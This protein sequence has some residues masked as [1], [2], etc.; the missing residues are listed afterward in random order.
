MI[1]IPHDIFTE[2]SDVDPNTLANL[3]PLRALAGSWRATKGSDVAP[4]P[5]GPER[6]EF[7]E[8]ITFEPIDPQA[9]GP[10]LFYG[11]RYHIHIT[12]VEEDI[13]FHEQVGYW[14]WEPATGLMLQTLAIPRGQTAMASGQGKPGDESITLTAKRGQTNYGI[15]STDFLEEA[16]R[17]DEYRIQITFNPDGSWSYDIQTTLSVHGQDTPFIH[18][19]RNTLQRVGDAVPNPWA[20]I[21]AAKTEEA[22]KPAAAAP[23]TSTT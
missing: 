9:N 17:T 6:R 21:I 16:F 10:Q 3:G 19:D 2:P 12:T 11:M 13:T 7:I 5:D 20:R 15:C 1:P 4:K 22:G 14:L 23:V 18:H 8:T